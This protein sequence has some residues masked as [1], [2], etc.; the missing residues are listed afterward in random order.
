M[1]KIFVKLINQHWPILHRW[2]SVFK[3]DLWGCLPISNWGMATC[4]WKDV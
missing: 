2:S 4:R 1:R 3:G